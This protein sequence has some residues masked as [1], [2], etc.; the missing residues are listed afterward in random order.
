MALAK[1]QKQLTSLLPRRCLIT[2][3]AALKPY[4]CD[5]LTA[6]REIPGLVVLPESETQI[7][8]ILAACL[9]HQVAVVPR[10]AGTG[11]SGG[12][13]PIADGVVIGLSRLNKILEFDWWQRC[14]ERWWGALP[15]IRT[16][17][18]QHSRG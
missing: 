4:E 3:P 11:L 13:R 15:Q 1:L 17:C 12:A 14:G 16:H 7:K 6:V 9:E 10:G 5:G 8:Q 2:D 18:A